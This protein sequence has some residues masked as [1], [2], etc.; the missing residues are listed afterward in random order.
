MVNGDGVRAFPANTTLHLYAD[1]VRF[2]SESYNA[3][4]CDAPT[5]F[6][7][8]G[9]LFGLC[10]RHVAIDNN[11]AGQNV[12]IAGNRPNMQVVNGFYALRIADNAEQLIGMDV[13]RR[14]FH[15]NVQSLFKQLPAAAPHQ[16]RY[17]HA[18][19]R[20]RPL[21]AIRH[22]SALLRQSPLSSR[23]NR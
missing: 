4:C 8:V 5:M 10:N 2:Q 14:T 3:R 23:I 19:N 11:M 22:H 12:D 17:Q 16:S 7:A 6:D 1:A 9:N 20:I 18:G 15:Q 21:P 13:F